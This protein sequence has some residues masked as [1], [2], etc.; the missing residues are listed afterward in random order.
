[1]VTSVSVLP[2]TKHYLI[3][4]EAQEEST[5]GGYLILSF[6]EGIYTIEQLKIFPVD[7]PVKTFKE[8]RKIIN[9]K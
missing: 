1:M 5:L 4:I 6:P 8:E 9:G 7:D 3:E 2:E